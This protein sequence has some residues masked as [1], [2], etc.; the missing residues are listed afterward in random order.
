MVKDLRI[1]LK[2]TQKQLASKV[3]VSQQQISSWEGRGQNITLSTLKKVIQ[4]FGLILQ[5]TDFP[6]PDDLTTTPAPQVDAV[7]AVGME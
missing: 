2:I 7:D 3:G 1:K 6:T 5:I 4:P